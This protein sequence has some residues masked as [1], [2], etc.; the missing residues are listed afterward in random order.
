LGGEILPRSFLALAEFV[1]TKLQ[2]IFHPC[3]HPSPFPLF[4]KTDNF[5]GN[6][7]IALK[8]CAWSQIRLPLL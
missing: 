8:E 1:T 3:K 4:F 5:E 2:N 7:E 6:F